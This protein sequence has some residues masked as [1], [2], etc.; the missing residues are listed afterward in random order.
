MIKR[1]KRIIFAGMFLLIYTSFFSLHAQWA[2]TYGGIVDDS[3]YSIQQTSDGGYIVAGQTFSFGTEA[4]DFWILKLSPDGDIEWQKAYGGSRWDDPHSIQQTSDGGYI[5]SGETGSFGAIDKDFWILKLSP[6]G[7]I[8]WQRTYGGSEWETD[9]SIQQTNDGGYIVV[10]EISSF[11]TVGGYIWILKLTS[12]GEIEW[13]KTYGGSERETDPSIRQTNDGGYIVAGQ[14]YSFGAEANDIWILKLSSD[15]DIDW[16]KTY[17]GTSYDEALSIQQTNDGGYIV[18]GSTESFG[19]GS[20]DIWILKLSSA[21]D[22]EWQKTYEG[23][24]SDSASSIQQTSDGG[25]IVAGYTISWGAGSRDFW[26]LKLSS[27]G[28]INP[29]C[30]FIRNSSAEVSDTDISPEVTNTTPTYKDITPQDT[31][32]TPQDTDATVYNLCSEKPLLGILTSGGGTTVPAPGTYIHEPGTEV[33]IT[34]FPRDG[35]SFSGWSGDASGETSPIT[36]IMDSDKSIRADFWHEWGGGDE[37]D[38]TGLGGGCFI[39]TAAYGSK[40]H[41]YVKILRDFRDT[42]LMPSE[43]GRA[44]V[45]LYYKYS[46]FAADIIAKH[47]ALKVAVRISLL[48]LIAISYTT[49][50]LGITITT[51]VLIF[52]FMLPVFFVWRYQR[53]LRRHIRGK[54]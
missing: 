17:G 54:K 39:A 38:E 41:N 25:Y 18:A 34:A 43:L 46:P 31:H 12:D 29:R 44:F 32:I 40:L 15:G 2:I 50:H 51:A 48:P 28:D 33:T 30:S 26:V 19:A 23:S 9:P 49:L 14:I 11:G 7:A 24:G 37:E 35:Y 4:S 47:K 21:G 53:K 10:G 20:S 36:I 42:C 27:D 8:E 52:I 6:D 22:I 45:R 13:Q 3:A 16:Q 1:L 5:V